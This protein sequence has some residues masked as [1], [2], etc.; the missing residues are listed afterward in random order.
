M[1]IPRH[2]ALFLALKM[3]Y[4]F[5]LPERANCWAV[6]NW[7]FGLCRNRAKPEL[8]AMRV[9]ING[10]GDILDRWTVCVCLLLLSIAQII[11][12]VCFARI[13]VRI[14]AT[15]SPFLVFPL[16]ATI[17]LALRMTDQQQ[18]QGELHG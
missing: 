3:L 7:F 5:V 18:Q 13:W 8:R 16:L 2:S 9:K 11:Q 1:L 12:M 15:I 4:N 17:G 10:I 6:I 14:G